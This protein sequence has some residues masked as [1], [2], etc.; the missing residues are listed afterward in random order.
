MNIFKNLKHSTFRM[1][2][3]YQRLY[4]FDAL[5]VMFRYGGGYW[6]VRVCI[7]WCSVFILLWNHNEMKLIDIEKTLQSCLK[8]I[9]L[10][11]NNIDRYF[12]RAFKFFF[13]KRRRKTNDWKKGSDWFSWYIILTCSFFLL[14]VYVNHFGHMHDFQTYNF[15]EIVRRVRVYIC[16]AGSINIASVEYENKIV[17]KI[18]IM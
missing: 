17:S 12:R 14:C 5:I 10:K 6:M 7:A 4:T 11:K 15:N 16:E 18:R 9:R 2:K 8:N 13:S 1:R 3:K